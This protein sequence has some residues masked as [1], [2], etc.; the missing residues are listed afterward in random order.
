MC[1]L[2]IYFRGTARTV[3]PALWHHPARGSPWIFQ[4]LQKHSNGVDGKPHQAADKRSVDTDI[5]EIASNGGLQS[6]GYGACVPTPDRVGNPRHDGSALIVDVP[7]TRPAG[8]AVPRT[9][10]AVVALPRMPPTAQRI[11]QDAES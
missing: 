9:V 8:I 3:R 4:G 10:Q 7:D 5:L 1:A 11:G 2:P 6:I